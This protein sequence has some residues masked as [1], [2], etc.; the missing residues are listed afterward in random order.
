ML[1]FGLLASFGTWEQ[2]QAQ[3]FETEQSGDAVVD[4][5]TL[6][7]GKYAVVYNDGRAVIYSNPKRRS[8]FELRKVRLVPELGPH[9]VTLALPDRGAIAEQ[10]M[11]KPTSRP[12]AP[13]EIIVVYRPGIMQ[14]QDTVS[15]KPSALLTQLKAASSY[16]ALFEQAHYTN[17]LQTNRMLVQL[18]VDRSQHLFSKLNGSLLSAMHS[19]TQQGNG[20]PVLDFSNAYKLHLIGATVER[21]VKMLAK[22]PSVAYVSPNWY[23]QPMNT[24]RMVIRR[25]ANQEVGANLEPLKLTTAGRMLERTNLPSNYASVSSF[26]S[27]LNAPSDDVM[28]AYDEIERR[29]HELPGQ[30]EI[31]TNVSI[32]DLDDAS[33]LKNPN[34][35]CSGYVS[36]DGPTSELRG[37]QRYLN[38]PSM[39][40]IPT[41]T[42]DDSGNVDGSGEV[43]GVDPSDGEIDLDFSMMAP[44]P[45]ELQRPGEVGQGLADLLGIAPGAKYRLVV[46]GDANS[47]IADIDG[48]LLGAA[49][50]SA[51]PN[52]IT[53]SL[54]FGLDVDGYPSR[55]LE[56]DALTEAIVAA[57]VQQ[58]H[59]AVCISAGD[60]TRTFTNASI[61]PSGGSAPENVVPRGGTPSMLD[62]IAYSTA[63]SQLWDSGSTAAGG[64][65]LDDLF[66]NPPQYEHGGSLQSQHA[67]AETRWTGVAAFSS[68]FGTRVDVSAPSDN[69]IAFEHTDGGA[70][71]VVDIVIEGGTSASSPEIAAAS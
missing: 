19:G 49:L 46:P 69:V 3:H 50:Q 70:A 12:Y 25:R 44:L 9:G 24:D 18:G 68:G 16:Q 51:P 66:S 10:L 36:F 41:Y 48:A 71:D 65:T 2:A 63:P 13:Q 26:Q 37:G 28:A 56:E 1:T 21:A 42:A 40:L 31:I 60:G 45:H 30:G 61:G 29:F 23:V 35:P 33:A 59:I 53:A 47:T 34:D 7:N 64:T 32:G 58:E 57:I 5:L 8:K 22:L 38:M 27:M 67:Y 20:Q 54:G 11:K 62:D 55:Y 52:V 17:D 15:I 4:Q 39:P 6:P 43:C 14:P